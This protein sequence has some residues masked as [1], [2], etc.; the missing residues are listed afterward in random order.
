M[1]IWYAQNTA[2]WN[3]A[4]QWNSIAAGGGTNG[5]PTNGDVCYA[6]GKT[7]TINI[8][9]DLSNTPTNGQIRTDAGSGTAGGLFKITATGLTLKADVIAGTTN[10]FQFTGTSGNS[11][12]VTGTITGGASA[13]AYGIDCTSTGTLNL[14]GNATGGSASAAYGVLNNSTGIVA[15]TGNTFGGSTVNLSH[16]VNN[17][18]TGTLTISGNAMAGLAGS[19]GAVNTSTGTLTIS[20]LAIGNDWGAGSTSTAAGVGV[21]SSAQGSITNIGG[22][23]YGANGQSPTSGPVKI[24]P[25]STNTAQFQNST[26]GTTKL[27]PPGGGML[28]F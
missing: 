28:L 2:N 16:G 3:A 19:V 4:N 5:T 21:A 8:S 17:A 25:A 9:V 6:N 20:G 15:I 7:V 22:I 11:T 10:C 1:S 23:Q 14:I 12:T 24:I 26:S 18:S 13:N 27:V